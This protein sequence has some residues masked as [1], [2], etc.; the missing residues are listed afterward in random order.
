MA[1]RLT[2]WKSICY[3]K[4]FDTENDCLQKKFGT[5]KYLLNKKYMLQ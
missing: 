1:I 4:V 3:G 2:C 5:E